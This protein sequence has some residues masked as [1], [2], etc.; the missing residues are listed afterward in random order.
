MQHLVQ[1]SSVHVTHLAAVYL[2]GS[3]QLLV[4]PITDVLLRQ[5]VQMLENNVL[6]NGENRGAGECTLPTLIPFIAAKDGCRTLLLYVC[7]GNLGVEEEHVLLDHLGVANE[8]ALR[9]G[10]ERAEGLNVAMAA[11]DV[12]PEV[13]DVLRGILAQVAAE[14]SRSVGPLHRE[15]RKTNV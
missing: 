10:S 8:E 12:A 5:T 1:S 4:Q 15:K 7:D 2:Y 11:G 13:V 3:R 14:G 9:A 6:L